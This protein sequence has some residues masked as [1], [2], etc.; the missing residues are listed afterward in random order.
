MTSRNYPPQQDTHMNSETRKHTQNL[1]RFQTDGVPAL[2]GGSRFSIP[3]LTKKVSVTDA[4][5][6]EKTT[7]LQWS[8]IASIS[9]TSGRAPCLGRVEPHG[10]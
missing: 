9:H 5:G 3:P 8:V 6:K 4:I 1:H 7:S 10:L 2:R